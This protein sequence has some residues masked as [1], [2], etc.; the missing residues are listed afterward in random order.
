MPIITEKFIN[1]VIFY[2]IYSAPIYRFLSFLN[3]KK[4]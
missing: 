1:D 2:P 3:I 4:I